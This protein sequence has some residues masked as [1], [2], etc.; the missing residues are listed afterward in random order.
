MLTSCGWNDQEAVSITCETVQRGADP[1]SA[2][3]GDTELP[4]VLAVFITKTGGR[5]AQNVTP[6]TALELAY[7]CLDTSLSIVYFGS[8]CVRAAD[9]S[10]V[11][12][13]RLS[14]FVHRLS[15]KCR[16]IAQV[17]SHFISENG[18]FSSFSHHQ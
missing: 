12:T 5:A 1:A 4:V 15:P 13:Q 17:W 10:P 7:A 18:V 16:N 8:E 2:G 14:S 3:D 9:V 11:L 6:V